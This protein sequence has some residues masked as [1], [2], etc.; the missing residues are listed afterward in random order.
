MQF[1][2]LTVNDNGD[3][4]WYSAPSHGEGPFD[5]DLAWT[6]DYV[7]THPD[8]ILHD[9]ALHQ[10]PQTY[11]N[12]EEGHTVNSTSTNES[13][14]DWPDG[15]SR[16]ASPLRGQCTPP[17]SDARFVDTNEMS[18]AIQ[19]NH[20]V[21]S[22]HCVISS[23]TVR[24]MFDL[25]TAEQLAG[26]CGQQPSPEEFPETQVLQHFLLL[27]FLHVHPR[28]PV[29]HL[30]TFSPDRSFPDMLLAMILAG[31][32]HSDSNQYTFCHAYVERTRMSVTLQRERDGNHVSIF[33]IG[34]S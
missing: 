32:C 22:R 23:A 27:Y 18:R 13:R 9:L 25:L 20:L 8:D 15:Q 1:P 26:F 33:W 21:L 16:S 17:Y 5:V 10:M 7:M 3:A 2:I 28:F 31:S 19:E 12:A 6:F 14:S 30:P 11:G 4:P 29:T 34:C 24:S